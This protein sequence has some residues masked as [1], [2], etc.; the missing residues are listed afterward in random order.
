[1]R[2]RKSPRKCP[3]SLV[4][5]QGKQAQLASKPWTLGLKG[6]WRRPST[7][8]HERPGTSR[9][10]TLH[11]SLESRGVHRR[12]PACLSIG[13]Q[14][15]RLSRGSTPMETPI[16]EGRPDLGRG[17]R[18]RGSGRGP[19]PPFHSLGLTRPDTQPPAIARKNSRYLPTCSRTSASWKVSCTTGSAPSVPIHA[20]TA[21]KTTGISHP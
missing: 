18:L 9:G 10:D 4:G 2:T 13:C 20:V 19:S 11:P 15:N 5:R 21:G 12:P 17:F 6:P 3:E 7:H 16:S 14:E 8:V 1:M